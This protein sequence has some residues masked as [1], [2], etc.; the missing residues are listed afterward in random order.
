MNFLLASVIDI[1]VIVPTNI[2]VRVIVTNAPPAPPTNVVTCVTKA[3]D[4]H[5]SGATDNFVRVWRVETNGTRR[6]SR[7]YT[8]IREQV[9]PRPHVPDIDLSRWPTADISPGAR[10][11][12]EKG[13]L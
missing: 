8:A 6:I 10:S 5:V 1:L 9:S 2:N 7:Y 13:E 4:Y 3:H 12:F 11:R